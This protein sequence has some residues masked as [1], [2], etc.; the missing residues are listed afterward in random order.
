MAAKTLNEG[1]VKHRMSF[2]IQAS[3][4]KLKKLFRKKDAVEGIIKESGKLEDTTSLAIYQSF[5]FFAA[6]PE[7]FVCLFVCLFVYNGTGRVM[8]DYHSDK[9]AVSKIH[10]RIE[11]SVWRPCPGSGPGP[12]AY[13]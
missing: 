7:R 11:S 1:D 3:T 10:R 9:K 8:Q 13:L 5:R 2:T 6:D 12:G 4:F